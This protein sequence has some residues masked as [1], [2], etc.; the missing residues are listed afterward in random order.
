MAG[1]GC[2]YM[3]TRMDRN[4]ETFTQMGGEGVPWTA[5]ARYTDEKHMF[6]NL[7]DGT[8][9]HSGILAVRQSVA[10]KVNVTYK[11][12]YNDA[13][14]MTGGQPID[15]Y[16]TPQLL[17]RQL[18][19]EGVSPIYLL[20]ENPSA[21][22][23]SDLAPGVKVLHRDNIDQVMLTLRET[24]GCSAIV[25]VQ[26]CAAEKRRRRSRGL[27]EDPAKRVFINPAVCEGCGDC[28][29]QSNCISVE[30]LETEFGRKRQINQSS[31]NK[32]FSCVKGFAFLRHRPWRS[33]PEA[34]SA[35]ARRC[36][37]ADA[38]D[39]HHWRSAVEHRHCR[40]RRH[41]HSDHRRHPR[42]GRPS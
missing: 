3:V 7:G 38:G 11:L 26:T 35:G 24:E 22:S 21:Y 4:T 27:L 1:I 34:R 32:D 37:C 17:T 31:C 30:P 15:G 28:S 39:P 14:A 33:A 29:V 25:Y 10:A 23:S 16:L 42:H 9:F 40:R 2:H 18:H 41:R 19:G 8:Y 13:V 5:I 36:R 6:V 12:L 20:S